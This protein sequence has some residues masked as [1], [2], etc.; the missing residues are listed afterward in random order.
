M[1]KGYRRLK[2]EKGLNACMVQKNEM[3]VDKY[4]YTVLFHLS[5]F[6]RFKLYAFVQ[7]FLNICFSQLQS[8]L[9]NT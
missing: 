5:Y 1:I 8:F 2:S 3:G 9:S 6:K 7:R 4:V